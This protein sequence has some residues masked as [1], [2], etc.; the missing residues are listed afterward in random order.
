MNVLR[1][2]LATFS[3][4]FFAGAAS[5]TEISYE[6]VTFVREQHRGSVYSLLSFRINGFKIDGKCFNGCTIRFSLDSSLAYPNRAEL[7]VRKQPHG[8]LVTSPFPSDENG[9]MFIGSGSTTAAELR[10]ISRFSKDEKL[11]ISWIAQNSTELINIALDSGRMLEPYRSHWRSRAQRFETGLISGWR[12]T[13]NSNDQLINQRNTSY[14]VRL[15]VQPALA[16]LGHYDGAIDG[17][18]GPLTKNAVRQ[19]QKQL[20][21]LASGYIDRFELNLL[22]SHLQE[23]ASDN[24]EEKVQSDNVQAVSDQEANVATINAAQKSEAIRDDK[25]KPLA[26]EET[27]SDDGDT[28]E[29]DVATAKRLS[30]VTAQLDAANS[31]IV[32]LRSKNIELLN[33]LNAATELLETTLPALDNRTKQIA[34]INQSLSELQRKKDQLEAELQS[35]RTALEDVSLE[36]ARYSKDLT[37]TRRQVGSLNQSLSEFRIDRDENYVPVQKFIEAEA[38]VDALN[39]TLVE[40]GEQIQ[41]LKSSNASFFG[42]C[43]LDLDCKK[44][45]GL[46]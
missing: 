31:V 5:A 41:R 1:Y 9:Q 29:E 35:T 25:A 22:S 26:D 2:W 40:K 3:M 39:S 46:P 23:G 44:A 7:N 37:A 10:A 13:G 24:P 36:A 15:I 4:V 18:A 27:A 30:E 21:R 20:G 42:W 12:R 33:D 43:Q 6:K 19:Y 11:A 28:T 45:F 38:R 14:D 32:D 16:E 17:M 34:A 8:S